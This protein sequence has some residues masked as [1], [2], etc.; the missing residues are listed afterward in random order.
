MQ[1]TPA[2]L[3]RMQRMAAERAN[4]IAVTV[5]ARDEA[6]AFLNSGDFAGGWPSWSAQLLRLRRLCMGGA[7]ARTAWASCTCAG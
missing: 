6:G 3:A 5:A 7:T 1:K 4:P 2:V